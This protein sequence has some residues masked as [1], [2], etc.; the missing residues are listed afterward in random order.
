MTGNL[1][2]YFTKIPKVDV[3]NQ[4]SIVHS[5]ISGSDCFLKS[6]IL[7]GSNAANQEWVDVLSD[8][9]RKPYF[10]QLSEF[11]KSEIDKYVVYPS[12]SNVFAWTRHCGFSKVKVVILG[13]DPYHQPKQAHGLSFSV[14]FGVVAP[15]SL[16]NIYKEISNC[17][18]D[19]NTPNHGCLQSWAEQG[20]LLL[21]ACLTVRHGEPNSHKGKGWEMLTDCVMRKISDKRSNV[22]FMLWGAYARQKAK[23]L[24]KKKHCILESAHPSPLSAHNGFFGCKHFSL[25]NEYLRSNQIDVINWN[26]LNSYKEEQSVTT[27]SINN[28]NYDVQTNDARKGFN[29][30][31]EGDVVNREIID[32]LLSEIEIDSEK[33]G[34]VVETLK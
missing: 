10:L 24:D 8:Q 11:V 20:V 26:S 34:N 27:K 33:A 3:D 9:F 14:P 16:K 30:Q 22:V 18:S 21:N 2:D 19:F 28:D 13:Q 7:N 6:V 32:A 29:D 31:I 4:E 23:L 17:I 15:P 5:K 25:A 12:E 1:D